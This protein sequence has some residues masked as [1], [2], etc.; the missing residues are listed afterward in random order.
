MDSIREMDSILS[1]IS[2]IPAESNHEDSDQIIKHLLDAVS[3]INTEN[4]SLGNEIIE[5]LSAF[6]FDIKSMSADLKDNSQ[7]A[8]AILKSEGLSSIDYNALK[9]CMEKR[10]VHEQMKAREER[11]F[12]AKYNA[13]FAKY[14]MLQE[15]L[16]KIQEEV[17][18]IETNLQLKSSQDENAESVR[19]LWSN[20]LLDYKNAITKLEEELEAIQ[21]QDIR[22]DETLKKSS[23]LLD[24]VNDLAQLNNELEK[25]ENLPTNLLQAKYVLENKKRELEEIENLIHDKMNN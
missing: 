7:T 17:K 19:I 6:K 11:L 16:N 13:A 15:K 14:N 24:K 25:Y 4:S 8:S 23:L 5:L 12:K 22:I 1:N 9:L 10:K 20:R 18:Q 3:D 21:F 2:S